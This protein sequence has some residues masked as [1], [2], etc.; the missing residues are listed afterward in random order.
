MPTCFVAMPITTPNPSIYQGDEEHFLHVLKCLFIPAIK[1]AGCLPVMPIAQGSE[2]IHADIIAN[3]EKCDLVLCDISGLNANV[4]FELGIRTALNKPICLVRDDQTEKI[5]F[6]TTLINH[7]VYSS[8]LNAWELEDEINALSEH[9]KQS[10]ERSAGQNGLWRHFGLTIPGSPAESS[11]DLESKVT[12][13]AQ[14]VQSLAQV[15]EA[16]IAVQAGVISEDL[17]SNKYHAIREVSA[18]LRSAG[19]EYVSSTIVMPKAAKMSVYPRLSDEVDKEAKMIAANYK[20]S[21]VIHYLGMHPSRRDR[22][23]VLV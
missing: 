3:I 18:F 8:L 17:S 1:N 10:L 22:T 20:W 16:N 15:V 19:A 14:Q 2:V 7:Y 4:F 13:L 5:P 6:D 11:T 12:L 9:I 21:V 23:H